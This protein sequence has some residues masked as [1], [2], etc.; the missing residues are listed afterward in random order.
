MAAML[1]R[2]CVSVGW[3]KCPDRGPTQ[4]ASAEGSRVH[5]MCTHQH[6]RYAMVMINAA[7]TGPPP[8]YL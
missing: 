2:G 6:G 3:V 8:R 5:F 4:A 1:L 7:H